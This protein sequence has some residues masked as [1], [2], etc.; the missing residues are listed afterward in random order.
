MVIVVLVSPAAIAL[1]S[2]LSNP[3]E[4]TSFT[5]LLDRFPMSRW[6]FIK[7]RRGELIAVPPP[8]EALE[9]LA[10]EEADGGEQASSQRR[11]VLG[12]PQTV[13]AGLEEVVASYGAEEAIVV[14]ITYEHEARRRSYELLAEAFAR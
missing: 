11:A 12:S 5:K 7:L 3:A 2:A 6:A 4:K 8:Q 13:R 14:S 9:F 10:A 1:A